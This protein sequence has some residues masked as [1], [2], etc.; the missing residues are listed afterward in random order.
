MIPTIDIKSSSVHAQINAALAEVGF[1]QLVNLDISPTLLGDV[2]RVANEFFENQKADK[3]RCRY[4][5][6]E[7]NFGYQGI[8]E[9]HLDPSAPADLKETFTM[10]NILNAPIGEERWPSPKF[11]NLVTEF[12]AAAFEEARRVLRIFEEVLNQEGGFFVDAHSGENVTLRV[13]YYPDQSASE[14]SEGQL[15]AGAHTDYGMMTLLFQD[16]IG[17]LQVKDARGQWIDAP[18]TEGA[19]VIN[20]GDLLERWTNGRF[21]S[22]LHRVQPMRRAGARQSIAFFV[23]PDSDVV[24]DVLD[25]C[26]D[27]NHPVKYPSI[28]AGAHL[29][30][31]ILRSH[32][33]G[34]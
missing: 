29:Q 6:A 21:R 34:A 31:K 1:M 5:S 28:T 30:E 24:V 13:L 27:T 19:V 22:T 7:E 25:S 14:V 3:V 12:Y 33:G 20:S 23:D 4:Q 15:G 32:K 16:E 11:R 26:V 10:R 2:Y 8:A 18:P 17:G 9:E